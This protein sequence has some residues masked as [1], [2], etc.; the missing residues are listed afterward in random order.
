MG[1]L[2]PRRRNRCRLRLVRRR[3][4]G[5]L[6]VPV[7]V[8]VVVVVVVAVSYPFLS[9]IVLPPFLLVRG[10]PSSVVRV[11]ASVV[12]VAPRESM[13]SVGRGGV[14]V[15]AVALPATAVLGVALALASPELRAPLP[16]TLWPWTTAAAGATPSAASPSRESRVARRTRFLQS[17]QPPWEVLFRQE[18]LLRQEGEVAEEEDNCWNI[19]SLP[20]TGLPPTSRPRS[21]CLP[22]VLLTPLRPRLAPPPPPLPLPPPTRHRL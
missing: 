10:L 21:P 13:F 7:V 17:P 12:V 1:L 22:L 5:R 9:P 2:E 16:S 11:A 14:A 6:V 18:D 3:W 8:M 4:L 19:L 15:P 20:L